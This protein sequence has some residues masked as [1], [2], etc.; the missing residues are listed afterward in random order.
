MACKQKLFTH[1]LLLDQAFLSHPVDE[2]FL[3]WGHGSAGA[4]Q[5]EAPSGGVREAPP[6]APEGP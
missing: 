6:R 2:R 4:R 3:F 1:D 5:L